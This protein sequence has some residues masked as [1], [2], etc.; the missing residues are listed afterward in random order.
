MGDAPASSRRHPVSAAG[1]R[2]SPVEGKHALPAA[3]RR[4][5]AR[6]A[7]G[8]G[9]HPETG[10]T[11]RAGGHSS[12][13]TGRATRQ[14]AD[15]DQR[16]LF[17]VRTT[18]VPRRQGLDLRAHDDDDGEQGLDDHAS[19]FGRRVQPTKV[20]HPMLSRRQDVLQIPPQEL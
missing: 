10:D 14:R 11:A 19:R 8:T 18:Q 2:P 20:S 4:E 5:G 3:A 7:S 9:A 6:S 17:A 13:A 12:S 1:Q 15:P 16:E